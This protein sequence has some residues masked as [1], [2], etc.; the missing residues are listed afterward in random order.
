M[1]WVPVYTLFQPNILPFLK[2]QRII[3]TMQCIYWFLEKENQTK[4]NSESE[5]WMTRRQVKTRPDLILTS[6]PAFL[7]FQSLTFEKFY[8]LPW[9]DLSNPQK[10]KKLSPDD[11][12]AKICTE[13]MLKTATHTWQ[14]ASWTW[15]PNYWQPATWQPV[16]GNLLTW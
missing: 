8:K 6:S 3:H 10:E 15:Q 16:D 4:K 1:L 5:A 12:K 11:L 2:I 7:L 14:P 9:M 13:A